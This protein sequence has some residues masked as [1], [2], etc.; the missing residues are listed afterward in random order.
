MVFL[1]PLRDFSV[2][3]FTILPILYPEAGYWVYFLPAT[4]HTFPVQQKTG[5]F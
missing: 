2:A 3:G 1:Y 4:G 5:N